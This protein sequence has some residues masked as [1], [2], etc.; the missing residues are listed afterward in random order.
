MLLCTLRA[1]RWRFLLNLSLLRAFTESSFRTSP[2]SMTGAS[3]C[4]N[5]LPSQDSLLII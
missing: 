3:L 5:S 2:L 4:L 1:L